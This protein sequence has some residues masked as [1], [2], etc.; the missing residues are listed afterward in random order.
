[1]R[2]EKEDE[3]AYMEAVE[4]IQQ[5]ITEN[6]ESMDEES[7]ESDESDE[8]SEAESEY[9][10]PHHTNRRKLTSRR[11]MLEDMKSSGSA[12]SY[13]CKILVLRTWYS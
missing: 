9:E 3:E 2:L 6:E 7:G 12:Q 5:A 10:K 11:R 8:S 13:L 1:M 4:V